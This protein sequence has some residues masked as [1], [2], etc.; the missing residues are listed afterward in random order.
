MNESL[1]SPAAAVSLLLAAELSPPPPGTN[2]L[3]PAFKLSEVVIMYVPG[4]RL[5]WKLLS[6]DLCGFALSSSWSKVCVVFGLLFCAAAF[7]LTP[8]RDMDVQAHRLS[9]YEVSS[10]GR[11][12]ECIAP[13]PMYVTGDG[14]RRGAAAGFWISLHPRITYLNYH[15]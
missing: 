4:W 8:S 11:I 7:F 2:V 6:L 3:A 5:G 14:R 12:T 9:Q 13:F 10:E 15:T 1:G